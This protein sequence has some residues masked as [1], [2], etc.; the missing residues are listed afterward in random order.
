MKQ[1]AD[2]WAL[3]GHFG[4]FSADMGVLHETKGRHVGA[5]VR[6]G[7]L[8]EPSGRHVGTRCALLAI[9]G[10]HGELDETNGRR[11]DLVGSLG[12]P[13]VFALIFFRTDGFSFNCY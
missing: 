10:R 9:F 7:E 13:L 11:G 6:H 4:R 12:R 3:G 8:D 1:V 2:T 5:W